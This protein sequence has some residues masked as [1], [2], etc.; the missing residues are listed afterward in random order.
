MIETAS[1]KTPNPQK[2]PS[3]DAGGKRAV[4][5]LDWRNDLLSKDARLVHPF[6]LK[7]MNT[8][9]ESLGFSHFPVAPFSVPNVRIGDDSGVG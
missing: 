4:T 3:E 6:A 5:L 9:A 1:L 7:S 8:G 2:K